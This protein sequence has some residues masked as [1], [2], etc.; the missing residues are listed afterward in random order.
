MGFTNS[1]CSPSQPF[2]YWFSNDPR[3]RQIENQYK[4]GWDG[5][6]GELVKP[7]AYDQERGFRPVSS[8]P[9]N[10]PLRHPQV[11]RNRRAQNSVS[12]RGG[13]GR[14]GFG[15]GAPINRRGQEQ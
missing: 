9:S 8:P 6:H 15:R 3:Q 1:P 4:K 10:T 2:L 11:S 5:E 7:M 13:R 14:G 12:G